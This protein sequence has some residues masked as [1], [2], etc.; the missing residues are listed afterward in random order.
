MCGWRSSQADQ[1]QQKTCRGLLI[2]VRLAAG[3]R[4]KTVM[5]CP[6]LLASGSGLGP[7]LRR[8]TMSSIAASHPALSERLKESQSLTLACLGHPAA[9]TAFSSTSGALPASGALQ[10][11]PSPGAASSAPASIPRSRPARPSA[12]S[13]ARPRPMGGPLPACLKPRPPPAEA[14]SA[15][16]ASGPGLGPWPRR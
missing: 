3:C 13:S 11:R 4:V 6:A 8:W 15:T 9:P 5:T 2:S 14:G 1:K 12:P 7:G 10:L 16:L